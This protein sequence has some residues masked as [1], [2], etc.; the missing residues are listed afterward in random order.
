[1]ASLQALR[2]E[3][4]AFCSARALA[5][6]DEARGRC[7]V[8]DLG[9]VERAHPSVVAPDTARALRAA[10]EGERADPLQRPRLRALVAFLA[11]ASVEA[12]ARQKDDALRQLRLIPRLLAGSQHSL[13]EAWTAVALEP[14]RARR[15]ALARGSAEAEL[16][17]LAAVQRRWEAAAG[18]AAA[19]GPKDFPSLGLPSDEAL[20][21]EA[22]RFL[23]STEDAW[24]EVLAYA[25][26]RLDVRLRPLPAGEAELHD[27]DRLGAE[28]LP[29]A[30]EPSL[31]LAAVRRWLEDA[32]LGLA[33]EGRLRLDDGVR[34]FAQDFA[35]EVPGEVRLLTPGERR[36]H[37]P[38]FV[39]L[40]AAGRARA[41]AAVAPTASLEAGRMG[42]PA[43][44]DAAG[45]SFR[46]LLRSERWLGRYLGH[47][48]R[49]AREVARLSALAELG[50]LRMLAARLP[51]VRAH[52]ESGPSRAFLDALAGVASE[53]LRVRV[54]PGALLPA[55]SGWPSEA[56]GLRAA[57]LAARIERAADERF[58]AE[59]FRNPGAA[60][61]LAGLW[62]R[63]TELD[64]EAVGEALGGGPLSLSEV[65]RRLLEVLGA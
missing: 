15:A 53:A 18:A 56:D 11:R 31:R 50:E 52:W 51:V 17:L 45:W 24:R 20:D 48:R 16:E 22:A 3:V 27:L 63:G 38:F 64:A 1:M 35:I 21:A 41:A 54:P 62:A 12:R 37:G 40:V 10:A 42:D 23:T 43:V 58:D 9:A 46:S 14:D 5:L 55:L 33:A 2:D 49:L 32:G 25:L 13:T 30:F 36:G 44:R 65:S 57:A 59:D 19:L 61:W 60:R 39:L 4:E 29:G 6:C 26:H 8:A 34:P 28:P 7:T 47:G